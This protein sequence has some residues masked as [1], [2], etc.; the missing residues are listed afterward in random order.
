MNQGLNLDNFLWG[1]GFFVY[2]FSDPALIKF[3]GNWDEVLVG[4]SRIRR[5]NCRAVFFSVRCTG[6]D[7]DV[8]DREE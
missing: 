1:V 3:S 5:G 7:R 8:Q 2:G 6:G 4:G